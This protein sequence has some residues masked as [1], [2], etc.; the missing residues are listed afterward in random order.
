MKSEKEKQSLLF[1]KEGSDIPEIWNYPLP[2]IGKARRVVS[3]C[4]R[5]EP[6]SSSVGLSGNRLYRPKDYISYRDAIGYLIKS[7]LGGEWNNYHYSFGIRVRFFLGNERKIDIDN[8]LKPIMDAGTHIVW[9]DDSQ[10]V[11]V[12]GVVLRSDPDPRIEALIY[13][14]EDFRNYHPV[15][16][17]CGKPLKN[18]GIA[19]SYCSKRCYD[20]AQRKGVEKV[21]DY[22][23]KS[24]WDGRLHGRRK[25]GKRFCSRDCYYAYRREHIVDKEKAPLTRLVFE[26]LKEEK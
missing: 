19:H 22:C 11:E 3:I 15:C 9:A 18:K 2:K 13:T 23:G 24:F 16:I 20:N 5:G 21:C 26:K 14:I 12:Y 7:Q 1:P 17:Y 8:L 25:K 10:V 4:F 6:V